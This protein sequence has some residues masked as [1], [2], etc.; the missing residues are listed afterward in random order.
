[1]ALAKVLLPRPALVLADEPTSG[2]DADVRAVV[3]ALVR[4]MCDA[5]TTFVIATH[6]LAL[7]RAVCDRCSLLFDGSI[8]CTMPTDRFFERNVLFR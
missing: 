3:H 8:A 4:E 6:D 1:M 7:A 5:G 2:L